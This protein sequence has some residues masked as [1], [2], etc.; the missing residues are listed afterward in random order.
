MTKYTIVGDPH[1]K[2]SNLDKIDRLFDLVEDIGNP[3]IWLGDLLDTK[4]VIRGNCLNLYH[5]R[6]SN[7]DLD[8]TI[9]VGNHDWFNLDCKDHSLK[10]LSL[11]ANVEVIDRPV[12]NDEFTLL[13]YCHDPEMLRNWLSKA[14]KNTVIG[15][16]DICGF[17]FGNG[18]I[19]SE[20]LKIEDLKLFQRVI[21]GHYH[22][23]Q[24]IKNVTYIGT[25]FSHSFG[26]SD[27]DKVIAVY[28]VDDD[29]LELLPTPFPRHRT[30]EL[31]CS[32]HYSHWY[33]DTDYFRVILKGTQE[34]IDQIPR[35]ENVKYV[36]Q[37]TNLVKSSTIE[38]T[39]SPEVQFVK[40][41]KDIK[42]FSEDV[43]ALG[44]EILENV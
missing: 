9:L 25:P 40:W 38:E 44:L 19:S 26:E 20:G 18:L 42:G 22:K 3:V 23:Y 2:P 5:E 13:P 35:M 12:Y 4:E 21:S 6:L 15:H 41:A 36:E 16:L 8:H 34:E 10:T 31:D 33:N 37:P 39:Q 17:D 11:L 1:A 24:Q 32:K 43:V 30:I 14:R 27:Q 7:S 29:T 28:D